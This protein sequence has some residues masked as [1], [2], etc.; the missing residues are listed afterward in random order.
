MK[1]NAF[2]FTL[3]EM[4]FVVMIAAVMMAFAV[5]RFKSARESSVEKGATGFLVELASAR[6]AFERDLK[7]QGVANPWSQLTANLQIESKVT[8]STD[9][10]LSGYLGTNNYSAASLRK[11]LF[12]FG[13]LTSGAPSGHK[14]YIYVGK[15]ITNC[16]TVDTTAITQSNIVAYTCKD[17]KGWAIMKDGSIR[18]L[19]PQS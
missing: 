7:M 18:S 6:S 9:K 2:G 11:A 17:G 8:A 16:G 1:K 19:N 14:Y 15:T 12:T 4:L 13:Y 3:V 10:T 5:P